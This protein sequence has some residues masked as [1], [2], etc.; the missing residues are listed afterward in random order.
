MKPPSKYVVSEG[1]NCGWKFKVRLLVL[2]GDD[3]LAKILPTFQW[4]TGN[5]KELTIKF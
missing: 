1:D 3:I 2:G 4:E 5:G